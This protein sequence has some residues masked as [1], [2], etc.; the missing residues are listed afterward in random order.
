MCTRNG[1]L[2]LGFVG[3]PGSG[4]RQVSRTIDAAFTDLPLR[5]LADAALQRARDLGV[6]HADFRLERIR[7]HPLRLHD[8]RRDTSHHGEDLGMAVRVLQNG[9]WGFAAGVDLSASA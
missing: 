7:N 3:T 8:A 1:G 2:P 4:G 9:S 5:A 6:E